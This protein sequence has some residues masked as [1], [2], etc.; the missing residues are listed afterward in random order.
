MTALRTRRLAVRAIVG[1][2]KYASHPE[3]SILPSRFHWGSKTCAVQQFIG[4]VREELERARSTRTLGGTKVVTTTYGHRHLVFWFRPL[5]SVHANGFSYRGRLYSW[6][7]IDSVDVLNLTGVNAGAAR[8]R[9]QIFLKDGSRIHLNCR[10]LEKAG[11]KPKVGFLSTRS[12]AFDELLAIFQ[13]R[14]I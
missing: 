2:F 8:Y 12:D 9:A 4:A 11:V 10:A 5:V 3:D 14:A 1:Q 13:R 7:D 6:S